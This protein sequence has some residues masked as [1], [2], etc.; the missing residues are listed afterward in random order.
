MSHVKVKYL[1][2]LLLWDEA[3]ISTLGRPSII[4]S[5]FFL[6]H[7]LHCEQHIRCFSLMHYI[8]LRLLTY[9]VTYLLLS[10]IVFNQFTFPEL[11]LLRVRLGRPGENN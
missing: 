2:E 11:G 3:N 10:V 9:L 6:V 1:S 8:N 7:V 4:S 5:S